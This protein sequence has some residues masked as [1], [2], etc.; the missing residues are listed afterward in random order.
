MTDIVKQYG[1][2]AKLSELP[3]HIKKQLKTLGR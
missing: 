2:T 3:A 1:K